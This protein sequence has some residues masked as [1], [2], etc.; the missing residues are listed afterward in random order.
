MTP[1]TQHAAFTARSTID[2]CRVTDRVTD[3]TN[4]S[5]NSQWLMHSMQPKISSNHAHGK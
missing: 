2:L 5:K 1:H 3:T 4:I